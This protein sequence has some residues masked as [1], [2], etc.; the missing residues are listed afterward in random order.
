VELVSD[1]GRALP[2][3]QHRGRTHVLGALG[4]RYLIRVRNDSGRRAEVVVSVDGRDVLDGQPA[5][6]NKRG[7]IVEPWSRVTID[8]FRVSERSVA[9]FRFAS[10]PDSYAAKM[11]NARDVGVIGVAV[12]AEL[13]RPAP[14]P[15]PYEAPADLAP[16]GGEK[17]PSAAG[18]APEEARRERR[19]LGTE[20]GEEHRSHVREVPFERLSTRPDSVLVLRYDD[21][22]GLLALGIDVDRRR[23]EDDAWMRETASPFRGNAFAEPPPGW[24]SR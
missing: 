10:V 1:R 2:T 24:R 21:R 12:F 14:V 11:G 13:E 8:G 5:G 23:G 22:R 4:E 19:G 16:Q 7:Y 17:A 6:W 3:F 9:A 20:F 15:T 18:S